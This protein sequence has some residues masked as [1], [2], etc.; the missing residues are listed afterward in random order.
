MRNTM[1]PGT[2]FR[3]H[4]PHVFYRYKIGCVV[5]YVNHAY[6]LLC[7]GG[8]VKQTLV[9]K[10]DIAKR[11]I[12]LWKHYDF[13]AFKILSS[14]VGH[15]SF[16]CWLISTD[17]VDRQT[18]CNHS[19]LRYVAKAAGFNGILNQ[20]LICRGLDPPHIPGIDWIHL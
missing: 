20:S 13:D 18:R 1:L 10:H 2:H 14:G 8:A 6:G 16:Y 9:I 19:I 12:R 7:Y 15:C 3:R 17:E 5:P 4:K 11:P